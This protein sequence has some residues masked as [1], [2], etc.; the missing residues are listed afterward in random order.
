MLFRDSILYC[1]FGRQGFLGW[2]D[3]PGRQ[4][5]AGGQGPWRAG[6]CG[7]RGSLEDRTSLGYTVSCTSCN[8][9]KDD[10]VVHAC[11]VRLTDSMG[12]L[13]WG[14]GGGTCFKG[15]LLFTVHE[16]SPIMQISVLFI[17]SVLYSVTGLQDSPGGQNF[18]G[19]QGD[20]R[21]RH[22]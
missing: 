1:V 11:T 20:W 2:Q 19:G 18:A 14:V 9:C 21:A 7:R 13:V 15:N 6:L 3:F 10:G 5:F 4:D 22:C 8:L 17:D 16:Y 12:S